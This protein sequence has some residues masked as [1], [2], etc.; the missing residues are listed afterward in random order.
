M[1]LSQLCQDLFISQETL[2]GNG[3]QHFE[4]AKRSR[5]AQTLGRMRRLFLICTLALA[6]LTATASIPSQLAALSGGWWLDAIYG[7]S[8]GLGGWEAIVPG[9]KLFCPIVSDAR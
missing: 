9:P 3:I 1:R 6:A 4:M 8:I 7:G 2:G 5:Y